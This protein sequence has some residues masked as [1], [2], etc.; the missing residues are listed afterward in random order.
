MNWVRRRS[1]W[2]MAARRHPRHGA[3]DEDRAAHHVHHVPPVGEQALA[4][5]AL[6]AEQAE[7][8]LGPVDGLGTVGTVQEVER[9][10]EDDQV[11]EEPQHQAVAGDGGEQDQVGLRRLPASVGQADP[12]GHHD[13]GRGQEGPPLVAGEG[14]AEDEERAPQQL[15]DGQGAHPA[16]QVEDRADQEGQQHRLG[17]GG[18]L[19]VEHV[20][21]GD[22]HRHAHPGSDPAGRELLHQRE[23]A[24]RGVDEAQAADDGSGHPVVPQRGDGHEGD[25]QDVG[26]RQPHAAQL[27][28]SRGQG[29]G[30][31]AGHVE[32]GPGVAV[33]GHGV[34]GRRPD[35]GGH[36]RPPPPPP[37]P[38]RGG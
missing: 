24:Q 23:D 9:V 20:E 33:E 26:Q 17:E 35:G 36:A 21:V 5:A 29:I 30:D 6:G 14:G 10:V 16:A 27:G 13:H 7:L 3:E 15:P 38:S 31:V 19:D 34:G 25:E 18:G 1:G 32:V 4:D 22:E 8:G 28:Q 37:P 2:R 11:V 12:D